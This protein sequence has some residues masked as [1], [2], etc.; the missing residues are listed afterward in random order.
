MDNNQELDLKKT[1]T[2][3][4]QIAVWLYKSS[5]K[6]TH[7]ETYII[8]EILVELDYNYEY[9][10]KTFEFLVKRHENLRAFFKL[11]EDSQDVE[12]VYD[13]NYTPRVLPLIYLNEDATDENLDKIFFDHYDKNYSI[14]NLPGIKVCLVKAKNGLFSVI[15]GHHCYLEVESAKVIHNEGIHLY[16]KI[17]ESKGEINYEEAVR[18][19]PIQNSFLEYLKES[20]QNVELNKPLVTPF[21][22]GALKNFIPGDKANTPVV[23]ILILIKPNNKII[24]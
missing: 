9:H 23:N 11:H 3:S 5:N 8:T 14:E 20:H 6:K 2:F 19:L 1:L 22:E 7:Y 16:Q 12:R 15:R 18:E 4:E 13:E 17:Y 21:L 10:K 24:I